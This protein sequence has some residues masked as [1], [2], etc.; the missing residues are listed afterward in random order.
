MG[1]VVWGVDTGITRNAS[2]A[3]RIELVGVEW[4]AAVWR[5]QG[6]R[7]APLSIEHTVGPSF[8]RTWEALGRGEVA[9]DSFYLPELR[10]GVGEAV[11]I[12][13]QGGTLVDVY[14]KGRALIQ[15]DRR[16]FRLRVQAI[17]WVWSGEGWTE[18]PRTGERVAAGLKAVE[19]ETRGGVLVVSMPSAG[20]SHH[21]EA[22]ALLRALWH[23]KAGE[24]P[25]AFDP[26]AWGE[27]NAQFRSIRAV[28][29]HPI[30][31]TQPEASELF[32]HPRA[33]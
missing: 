1:S 4:H 8:R 5:W 15:E 11:S 2:A 17:G 7:G 23:A 12:R 3:A 16:P 25:R 24:G 22:V 27:A 9:A 32:R 26:N 10:R 21:D 19:A 18:D 6:T 20:D 30:P 13:A 14:G 33:R 28:Q 31:S 29:S